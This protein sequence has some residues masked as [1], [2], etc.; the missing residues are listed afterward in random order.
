[1]KSNKFG[2]VTSSVMETMLTVGENAVLD[3]M[4][5]EIA[6][7]DVFQHLTAKAGQRNRAIVGWVVSLAFLEHCK[8]VGYFPVFWDGSCLKELV[9]DNSQDRRKVFCTF[10]Q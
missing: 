10:L 3:H 8:N 7:Y 5:H 2:L 6:N 9:A 4:L 1:M